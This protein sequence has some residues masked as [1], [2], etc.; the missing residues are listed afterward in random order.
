MNSAISKP[1]PNIFKLID[2][3]KEHEQLASISF[4]KANLG[5]VESRRTKEDL[6]DKEI[7]ILKLKYK[8]GIIDSMDFLMAVSSF[9][10][11]FE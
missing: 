2:L 9:V 1:H 4:E 6:K 5:Q 10:K 3:L 7:E 11:D 8:T